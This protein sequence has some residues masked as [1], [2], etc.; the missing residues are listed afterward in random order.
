MVFRISGMLAALILSSFLI[1]ITK[2]D[3]EFRLLRCGNH[4]EK[5][6]HIEFTSPELF[7][8]IVWLIISQLLLVILF[9][10]VRTVKLQCNPERYRSYMMNRINR[11]RA[12]I[13]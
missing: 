11:L 10:L 6:P 8:D 2:I 12:R 1:T 13:P 4:L 3:D 5:C 7:T 9:V